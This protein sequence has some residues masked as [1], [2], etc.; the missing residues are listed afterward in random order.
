MVTDLLNLKGLP[1]Q[2]SAEPDNL[3]F[4]PS[5][6]TVPK[7]IPVR[8]KICFF[9]RNSIWPGLL[10]HVE[11]KKLKVERVGESRKKERKEKGDRGVGS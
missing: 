5:L 7:K 10:D 8:S 3:I 11:R 2:D 1:Y 9:G 4:P 6:R